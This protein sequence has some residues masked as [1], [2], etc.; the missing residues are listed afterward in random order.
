MLRRISRFQLS[1]EKRG[2]KTYIIDYKT[3]SNPNRLKINLNKLDLG[4]RDSWNEAIGSLQLPFYIMLYAEKTGV[5]IKDLNGLF[6]LLGR[7]VINKDIELRLFED[8]DE[9]QT[10]E[11]LKT[12]ILHLLKEIVD[13]VHPFKPAQDKKASCPECNFKYICGT[14]WVVK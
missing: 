14:Q 5:Q 1:I 3:G 4:S 6:L 13:P 7:T 2:G 10:F 12:V 11:T 8:G 9:E